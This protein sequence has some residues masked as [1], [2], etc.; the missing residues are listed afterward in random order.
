MVKILSRFHCLAIHVF[1][2][3]FKKRDI[4]DIKSNT[5]LSNFQ[6]II[7]QSIH[8]PEKDVWYY[9]EL[10]HF[11]YWTV[12][13]NQCNFKWMNESLILWVQAISNHDV[14]SNL[15]NVYNEN[16]C[17]WRTGWLELKCVKLS[18]C[19]FFF[20]FSSQFDRVEEQQ[21]WNTFWKKNTH[22][23]TASD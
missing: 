17:H 9:S 19:V 22:I 18:V 14:L 7:H 2:T 3:L 5:N 12:S 15:L 8:N 16:M 23:Y 11:K 21:R 13:K 1:I 10:F 6:H 20:T 4:C